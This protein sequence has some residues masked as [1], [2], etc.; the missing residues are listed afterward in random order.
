MKDE[1]SEKEGSTRKIIHVV[2]RGTL[3]LDSDPSPNH[4][5]LPFEILYDMQ[6]AYRLIPY[7]YNSLRKFLSRNK[8]KFPPL[9]RRTKGGRRVRLI[10]ASEICRIRDMV[11]YG[12]GALPSKPVIAGL[13]DTSAPR[14]GALP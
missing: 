2:E 7:S 9:Y 5:L 12:P 13:L 3:N 1:V 6:V 11:L 14:P 10:S 4:W 8:A